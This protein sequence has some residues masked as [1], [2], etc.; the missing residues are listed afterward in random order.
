L[1]DHGERAKQISSK[2]GAAV[3]NPFKKSNLDLIHSR[4]DQLRAQSEQN[5]KENADYREQ[6]EREREIAERK[7]KRK[8]NSYEEEHL[9]KVT[10]LNPSVISI[11]TKASDEDESSSESSVVKIKKNKSDKKKKKKEKKEKKKKK[12]RKKNDNKNSDNDA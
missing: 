12:N 4:I 11:M 2:L 1:Q 9:S 3:G 7:P 10:G 8:F 5:L 6:M